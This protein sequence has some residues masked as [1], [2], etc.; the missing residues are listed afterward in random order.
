MSEKTPFIVLTVVFVV[1]IVGFAMMMTDARTGAVSIYEQTREDT[2]TKDGDPSVYWRSASGER[3]L[4]GSRVQYGR[5]LATT[6]E[7]TGVATGQAYASSG[8]AI[9]NLGIAGTVQQKESKRI[10]FRRPQS[11]L[12]CTTNVPARK[13]QIGRQQ[14]VGTAS[15]KD[16]LRRLD[17]YMTGDEV[18]TPDGKTMM[19]MVRSAMAGTPLVWEE[20]TACC[21]Y[22]V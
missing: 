16:S 9:G 3:A 7:E 8:Q 19:V 12:D 2:L 14:A 6:E 5:N 13:N 21:Y 11:H 20:N 17:C 15:Q 1:G 22:N 18:T 4:Y 10:T